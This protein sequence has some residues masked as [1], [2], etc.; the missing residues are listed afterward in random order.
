MDKI[1]YNFTDEPGI[2]AWYDLTENAPLSAIK[3]DVNFEEE[4]MCCMR[5]HANA[6][7]PF[8]RETTETT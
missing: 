7:I 6:D 2:K 3:T 8:V 1:D 4:I 5:Y